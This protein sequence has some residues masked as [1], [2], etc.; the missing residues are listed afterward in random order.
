MKTK[1]KRI[2]WLRTDEG[3]SGEAVGKRKV[4]AKKGFAGNG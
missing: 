3:L 4:L 2:A 1:M